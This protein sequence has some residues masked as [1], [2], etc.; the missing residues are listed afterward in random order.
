MGTLNDIGLKFLTDKSSLTHCYLDT[1]E[2]YLFELK[3]KE[4]TLLELG[5]AGGASIKTWKEYFTKAKVYGIDNNPTCTGEGIFIGD[6][7]DEIFMSRVLE[8]I[9]EVNV[10]IEDSSHI[11]WDMIKIFEFMFPKI[12]SGGYFF[13]E[14]THVIYS[15]H[16][17][18]GSGAFGFFTG[19]AKDVDIAGRGMTGNASYALSVENPTFEPIPKYSQYLKAMHLY[20][21]LWI[22]ER[23]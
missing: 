18:Q 17:E 15:P 6:A 7:T 12:K 23:K 2:K 8:Q 21:S 10:L 9:G 22:F 14:D 13:L 20:P 16:Y 4:F 5:V 19:L 1:Y 11:G 3:D